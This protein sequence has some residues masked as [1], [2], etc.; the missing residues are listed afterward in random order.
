MGFKA[1][2]FG[3]ISCRTLEGM[4]KVFLMVGFGLGGI[5]PA[6][7]TRTTMKVSIPVNKLGYLKSKHIPK[8]LRENK[9]HVRSGYNSKAKI[10]DIE[11]SFM[12]KVT[13]FVFSQT[14]QDEKYQAFVLDTHAW[15]STL[16]LPPGAEVFAAQHDPIEYKRMVRNKPASVKRLVLADAACLDGTPTQPIILDVLDFCRTWATDKDVVHSRFEQGLYVPG[17]VVRLTVATRTSVAGPR[18]NWV[19]EIIG[20]ITRWAVEYGLGVSFIPVNQWGPEAKRYPMMD[21]N[22]IVYEHGTPTR[23]FNMIFTIKEGYRC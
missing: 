5:N 9:T 20:D 15:Q 3:L 16:A 2:R 1:V 11:K 13:A 12:N 21:K 4:R 17:T 14:R 22:S 19:N 8:H 7:M 18:L 23:M 6:K 10:G